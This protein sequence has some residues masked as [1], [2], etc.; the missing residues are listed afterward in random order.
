M[1][2]CTSNFAG[3]LPSKARLQG[4]KIDTRGRGGY[5]LVPPSIVDGKE[6]TTEVQTDVAPLPDWI[7]ELFTP[8]KRMPSKATGAPVTREQL[9]ARLNHIDPDS[10]YEIW[11]NTVAGIHAT[12]IPDDAD[13]SYRHEL[14]HRWE[15][16]RAFDDGRRGE[17]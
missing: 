3:S 9:E 4:L 6:Y 15:L 8:K 5:V 14:A 11:R 1:A 10:D 12:N 7:K 16:R 17:I 13:G 2:A